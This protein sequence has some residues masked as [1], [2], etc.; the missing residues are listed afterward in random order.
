M[1]P[2]SSTDNLRQLVGTTLFEGRYLLREL[3]QTDDTMLVLYEAVDTMTGREVSTRVVADDRCLGRIRNEINLAWALQDTHLA[4]ILHANLS[5]ELLDDGTRIRYVVTTHVPGVSLRTIIHGSQ[6]EDAPLDERLELAAEM[7]SAL[8]PAL[9][10][11]HQNQVVH[12]NLQPGNIFVRQDVAGQI[13]SWIADFGLAVHVGA[14]KDEPE[15]YVPPANIATDERHA[16]PAHIPP[17]QWAK[18]VA[19]GRTDQYTLAISI[20]ELLSKGVAPYQKALDALPSAEPAIGATV[21]SPRAIWRGIHER[22]EPTPL[23]DYASDLLPEVWRV[24]RRALEKR[25]EDR[26]GTMGEFAIAFDAAVESH[27]R[28]RGGGA[29]SSRLSSLLTDSR[30]LRDT[31]PAVAA[32][33]DP[34]TRINLRL[35]LRRNLLIGLAIILSVSLLIWIIAMQRAA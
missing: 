26:Y 17:E 1:K 27:F 18:T 15:G 29:P 30:A 4:A 11:L 9:D 5:G 12:C 21:V 31:V 25:P 3:R 8:T 35:N 22:V 32:A 20:Y 34:R 19:D 16:N 6:G 24:L 28:E 13:H 7:V 14:P 23:T 10:K 33:P 2:V